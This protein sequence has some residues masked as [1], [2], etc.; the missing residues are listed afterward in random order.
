[1]E[2]DPEL[3]R[4]IEHPAQGSEVGKKNRR[5]RAEELFRDLAA[6][7]FHLV[8]GPMGDYPKDMPK[9]VHFEEALW[10]VVF[11]DYDRDVAGLVK[12]IWSRKPHVIREFAEGL[13][14]EIFVSRSKLGTL[15]EWKP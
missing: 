5:L 11:E 4:I 13:E 6:A 9:L 15:P 3:V 2:L 10:L 1:M 8:R 12:W 7:G 14:P